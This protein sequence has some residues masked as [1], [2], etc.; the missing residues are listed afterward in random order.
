MESVLKIRSQL[1]A[2]PTSVL[3]VA[4]LAV[5]FTAWHNEIFSAAAWAFDQISQSYLIQHIDNIGLGIGACF[6]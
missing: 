6:G 1:R 5:G 4:I 3:A 2:R